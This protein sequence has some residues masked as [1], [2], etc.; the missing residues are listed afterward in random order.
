MHLGAGKNWIFSVARTIQQCAS[1]QQL[2]TDITGSP[3]ND[4]LQ[5]VSADLDRD[6]SDGWECV[7]PKQTPGTS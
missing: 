3:V 2:G 4:L 6:L 7:K 1:A 5:I